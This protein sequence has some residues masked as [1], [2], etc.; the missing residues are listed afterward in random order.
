MDMWFVTRAAFVV[1]ELFEMWL[2]VCRTAEVRIYRA[3]SRL[4]SLKE[5]AKSGASA[6]LKAPR[7]YQS[8]LRY[9]DMLCF[10]SQPLDQHFRRTREAG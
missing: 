2:E 1:L 7:A 4:D 8:G 6:A 9:S 10:G 5:S 3:S